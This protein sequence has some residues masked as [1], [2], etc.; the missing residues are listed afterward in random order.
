MVLHDLLIE[1]MRAG[2]WRH[3]GLCCLRRCRHCGDSGGQGRLQA[4]CLIVLSAW[5]TRPSVLCFILFLFTLFVVLYPNSVVCILLEVAA[6]KNSSYSVH[7]CETRIV[8]PILKTLA[9]VLSLNTVESL[10]LWKTLSF[11]YY[12]R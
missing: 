5:F 8:V 3:G 10:C 7:F 2:R 1:M 4:F 11:S 12:R 6:K 9:P